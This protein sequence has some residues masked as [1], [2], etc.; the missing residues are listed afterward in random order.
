MGRFVGYKVNAVLRTC[1]QWTSQL[2]NKFRLLTLYCT[3]HWSRC[4]KTFL[5]IIYANTDANFVSVYYAKKGI[6]RLVPGHK[7]IISL[8][9]KKNAFKKVVKYSPF[10]GGR[11]RKVCNWFLSLLKPIKKLN[12]CYP[13]LISIR[14]KSSWRM[15]L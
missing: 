15:G 13:R 6:V 9:M 14:K 2:R 12:F 5:G 4:Y 10:R 7:T 8:L 3:G 11:G 1:L